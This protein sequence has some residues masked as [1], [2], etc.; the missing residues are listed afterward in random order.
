MVTSQVMDA[1]ICVIEKGYKSPF[2]DPVT[3]VHI[4]IQTVVIYDIEIFYIV[5]I[6]LNAWLIN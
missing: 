2:S 3:Y 4:V 6:I 1:Q 5:A